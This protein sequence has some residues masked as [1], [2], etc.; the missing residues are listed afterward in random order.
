MGKTNKN[1]APRHRTSRL[2]GSMYALKLGIRRVMRW[3]SKMLTAPR[4]AALRSA[5]VNQFTGIVNEP[6]H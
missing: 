2:I 3:L 6:V 5:M 1:I 4:R